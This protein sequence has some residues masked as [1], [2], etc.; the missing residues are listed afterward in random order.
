MA[1][2]TKTE[3]DYIDADNDVPTVHFSAFSL[4]LERIMTDKP[5]LG[6]N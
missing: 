6:M 4:V 5:M 2:R 1:V 3:N